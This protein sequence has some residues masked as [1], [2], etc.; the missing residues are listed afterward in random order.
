MCVCGSMLWGVGN[1]SQRWLRRIRSFWVGAFR[2][3]GREDSV[4]SELNI[5]VSRVLL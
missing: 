2:L 4:V 1:R 5:G 3:G